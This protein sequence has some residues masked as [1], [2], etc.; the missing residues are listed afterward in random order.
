MARTLL[1]LVFSKYFPFAQVMPG[2][3]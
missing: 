2:N 1:T 3:F